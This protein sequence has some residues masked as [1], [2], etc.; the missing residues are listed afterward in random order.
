M[1]D[2][3]RSVP[4][5]H[6]AA[7][8]ARDG[9]GRRAVMLGGAGAIGS[10]FL[11]TRLG[12]AQQAQRPTVVRPAANGPAKSVHLVGTDG[13][14]SMPAGSPPDLPFFP[15]SLAPDGFD[16][17]VFGFRDVTQMSTAEE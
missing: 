12:F 15:D 13:W 11:G 17:Y 16:T 7:T 14:V 5:F 2:D 10:V 4:D 3:P 6:P 8:P 9:L 1:T